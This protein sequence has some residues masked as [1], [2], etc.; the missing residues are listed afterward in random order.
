MQLYATPKTGTSA[1]SSRLSSFADTS[2]VGGLRSLMEPNMARKVINSGM[3]KGDDQLFGVLRYK[4]LVDGLC[5]TA[6]G[7]EQ[8]CVKPA[9]V[10]GT[11]KHQS[12]SNK[13]NLRP[14]YYLIKPKG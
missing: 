7:T 4:G 6:V 8:F 13:I 3:D 1:A 12:K 14:G 11:A 10:C 5:T 9:D 2:R